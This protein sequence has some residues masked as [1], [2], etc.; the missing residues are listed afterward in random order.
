LAREPSINEFVYIFV[1][2]ATSWQL[3]DFSGVELYL[4]LVHSVP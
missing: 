2:G 3:S 1:K 4:I